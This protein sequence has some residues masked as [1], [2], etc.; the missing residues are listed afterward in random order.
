[1]D[2][3]K[4]EE[5]YYLHKMSKLKEIDQI[6]KE[7]NYSKNQLI[8]EKGKVKIPPSLQPALQE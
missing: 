3:S 2:I 8:N 6:L 4:E 5:N 7:N 1:M